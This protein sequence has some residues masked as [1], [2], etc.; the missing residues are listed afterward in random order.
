MK[1]ISLGIILIVL[2][3]CGCATVAQ[4]ALEAADKVKMPAFPIESDLGC[5]RIT[6]LSVSFNLTEGQKAGIEP[7]WL[8][9][10]LVIDEERAADSITEFKVDLNQEVPLI[11]EN[12]VEVT[13]ICGTDR[14][15]YY[16]VA[17]VPRSFVDQFNL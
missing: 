16:K 17:T 1:N 6:N 9:F 14:E 15:C 7:I 12:C 5:R 2:N 4:K 3:C 8:T 10:F 13:L 11:H